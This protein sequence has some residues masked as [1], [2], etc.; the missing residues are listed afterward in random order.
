MGWR[1]SCSSCN[2]GD[3]LVEG[4]IVEL[5]YAGEMVIDG[6]MASV[7]PVLLFKYL[8]T[9]FGTDNCGIRIKCK[10]CNINLS[11]C[12]NCKTINKFTKAPDTIKCNCGCH[13]FMSPT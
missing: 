5:G 13:Y 11:A 6:L 2:K 1:G 8:K 9:M 10:R 4:P 12:P 7:N 3:S